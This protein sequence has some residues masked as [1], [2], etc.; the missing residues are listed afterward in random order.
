MSLFP[1]PSVL[2]E[3]RK[4]NEAEIEKLVVNAIASSGIG[5]RIEGAVAHAIN[6]Y[7][8]S[9]AVDDAVLDAVRRITQEEVLGN[10]SMRESVRNAIINKLTDAHIENLLKIV[11]KM[12]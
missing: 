12:D 7:A 11:L 5:K 4:M 3:K 1:W 8:F 6:G 10:P 2:L 9:K